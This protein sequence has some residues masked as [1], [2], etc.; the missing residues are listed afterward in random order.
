ML[1]KK[2]KKCSSQTE[3]FIT[4]IRI[5]EALKGKGCNFP[6]PNLPILYHGSALENKYKRNVF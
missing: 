6:L 4:T 2:I 5:P 1:N 3:S